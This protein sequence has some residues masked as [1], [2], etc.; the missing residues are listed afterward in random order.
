LS[1]VTNIHRQLAHLFWN[2][3]PGAFHR[4]FSEIWAKFYTTKLSRRLI[5]PFC[6]MYAMD[7]IILDKY[8]PASELSHYS[9]FQDFFTRRLKIPLVSGH[10]HVWPCQGYVCDFGRIEDLPP[11][12]I[13]GDTHAVPF[14]FGNAQDRIPS[15]YFFMNI[16]LHNHNYHRFHSP[17]DGT[18]VNIQYVKGQLTFLRP[19]LYKKNQ[20]SVPAFKNERIIM[21]IM[22]DDGRP[23]F[24]TFIGGMGV[25]QIKMHDQIK[26]GSR[27]KHAEEIGLFLI[28]STCCM[29]IPEKVENLF[30]MKKVQVGEKLFS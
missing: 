15:D 9:S 3:L 26:V 21:E 27:I 12:K 8:I 7:D 22:D 17:V 1:I 30:Y 14:I 2:P 19:W 25:G 4:V 20:V 28:G 5:T 23:W 11:V 13:K 24:I 10:N 16:F 18:I 29:A 6:S